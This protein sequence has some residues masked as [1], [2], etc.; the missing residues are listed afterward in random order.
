MLISILYK[1]V[2]VYVCVDSARII[3]RDLAPDFASFHS[4]VSASVSRVYIILAARHF[5]FTRVFATSSKLRAPRINPNLNDSRINKNLSKTFFWT[6]LSLLINEW[7]I[8]NWNSEIRDSFVRIRIKEEWWIKNK[9]LYKLS[10]FVASKSSIK[11]FQEWF[12]R[13]RVSF[14]GSEG[15]FL[16]LQKEGVKEAVFFQRSILLKTQFTSGNHLAGG[17]ATKI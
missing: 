2:C 15:S 3:D 8:K 7:R 11:Y 5:S 13:L 16:T 17:K 10:I 4:I 6:I 9:G 12:E 1:S 14:H